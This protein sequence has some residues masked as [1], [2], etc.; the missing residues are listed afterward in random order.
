MSLFLGRISNAQARA[1]EGDTGISLL[2]RLAALFAAKLA[3]PAPVPLRL[4]L[5]AAKVA[6]FRTLTSVD[7][8]SASAAAQP[9][10]TF[11]CSGQASL[12]ANRAA[13][14]DFQISSHATGAS[15]A[16][17]EIL[18]TQTTYQRG[19][20]AKGLGA[21]D[22]RCAGLYRTVENPGHCRPTRPSW[23]ASPLSP[24]RS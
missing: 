10:S 24:R 18:G 5:A 7:Q 13:S 4:R 16:L 17:E 21:L 3:S 12:P 15:K 8:S 19:P 14:R 6:A 2:L 20:T 23:D 22:R 11:R 1:S 9:Q